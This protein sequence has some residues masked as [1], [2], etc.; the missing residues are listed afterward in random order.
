MKPS[1]LKKKTGDMK[2]KGIPNGVSF[3]STSSLPDPG[4]LPLPSPQPTPALQCPSIIR[5]TVP[6][7]SILFDEHYSIKDGPVSSH[8]SSSNQSVGS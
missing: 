5:P 8:S 7:L 4:I 2:N 6:E 3:L 1:I